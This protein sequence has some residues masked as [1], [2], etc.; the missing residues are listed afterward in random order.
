MVPPPPSRAT[1]GCGQGAVHQQFGLQVFPRRFQAAG[2]AA[3]GSSTHHRGW[4]AQPQ[5]VGYLLRNVRKWRTT[6]RWRRETAGNTRRRASMRTTCSRPRQAS[7]NEIHSLPLATDFCVPPLLSRERLGAC[8][9]RAR[10]GRQPLPWTCEAQ[11]TPCPG[12]GAFP[13]AILTAT[14]AKFVSR[15]TT[16]RSP[17]RASNR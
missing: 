12:G 16:C 9:S 3:T 14:T 15:N 4:T 2:P 13:A 7:V 1:V 6:G 10:S 8:T 11:A 17:T 5:V